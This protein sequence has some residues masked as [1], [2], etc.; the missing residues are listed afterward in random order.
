[1]NLIVIFRNAL[2]LLTWNDAEITPISSQKL[3]YEVLDD[4]CKV[5]YFGIIHF[6][7]FSNKYFISV[8]IVAMV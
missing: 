1:M 4:G 7:E 3:R 2:K 8:T 6:K 5:S